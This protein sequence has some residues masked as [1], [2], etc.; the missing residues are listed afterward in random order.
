MSF[1]QQRVRKLMGSFF[2]KLVIAIALVIV[3]TVSIIG[4][5]SYKVF[6]QHFNKEIMRFNTEILNHM[7]KTIDTNYFQAAES[8][9]L[10][11][12]FD[13]SRSEDINFFLNNPVESNHSRIGSVVSTLN[14]F[15]LSSND[16]VDSVYVYYK[17]NKIVISSS[18]GIRYLDDNNI[19]TP[20]DLQWIDIFKNT[21]GN[22]EWIGT[23]KAV[24]GTAG[25]KNIV[26]FVR[27]LPLNSNLSNYTGLISVNIKEEALR[28]SIVNISPDN[29]ENAF[30]MD[31]DGN[32]LC[33]KNSINMYTNIQD[34]GHFKKIVGAEYSNMLEDV[35][36]VEMVISAV[37][38]D[39]TG[40]YYVYM[41]PS[42]QYYQKTFIIRQTVIVICALALLLALILSNIFSLKLTNP[43][44][45]L[46]GVAREI[47]KRED[48]KFP[49]QYNE[50]RLLDSTLNLLSNKV[51]NLEGILSKNRK[52]IEHT[53]FLNLLGGSI[54]R[55]DEIYERLEFIGMKFPHKYFNV[56]VM[57]F[58]VNLI[59]ASSLE[60]TEYMLYKAAGDISV[61]ERNAIPV[62]LD[63]YRIAVIYNYPDGSVEDMTLFV[64]KLN[65]AV[66]ENF[67]IPVQF[68][69][70]KGYT[71]VKHIHLAFEEA[72]KALAYAAVHPGTDIFKSETTSVW[73]GNNR[74]P[75][76][77]V[78]VVQE[79]IKT[80]SKEKLR[81]LLEDIKNTIV[82][83]RLSYEKYKKVL[84]A[85]SMNVE[86]AAETMG[87][88]LE[89]LFGTG[90]GEQVAEKYYIEDT[91]SCLEDICK[92]IM[93]HWKE[94]H[95]D[96]NDAYVKKAKEFIETNLDK[97]ISLE[98]VARFLFI[99]SAHLSRIF[100]EE[101]CEN[102]VEYVT[103]LRME[104]AKELLQ[105]D[106]IPVKDIAKMVG[107][108][109]CSY[110]NRKFK[111]CFGVTPSQF[112]RSI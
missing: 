12:L 56:A 19:L 17:N 92:S 98:S 102:F 62:I 35:D 1:F 11:L 37:K 65:K 107:F 112:R 82:V 43:F 61:Q 32:I 110:F 34:S 100:K 10:S 101:T 51:S 26:S 13:K 29:F 54:S 45:R 6:S 84:A 8:M 85:V 44:S 75:L 28:K 53:F 60:K 38:S 105:K 83:E 40:W 93:E 64:D 74:F 108:N 103:S 57:Q 73:D 16:I 86:K 14:G 66:G 90:I 3:L 31:G 39:F 76:E 99:S 41:V 48:N 30:I 69:T 23:R 22:S 20:F 36:G 52:M 94:R 24:G 87:I 33:H 68:G 71:S 77:K 25:E 21:A 95:S 18:A 7:K 50:L 27:T 79:Y 4:I 46:T 47:M 96:V 67:D 97:D 81:E 2:I 42:E 91:F 70:G 111:S 78:G 88:K 89:E 104:K 9:V 72:Q 106:N 58:N 5:T 59:D 55:E 63:R 15:V 80:C 109:D 49:Q